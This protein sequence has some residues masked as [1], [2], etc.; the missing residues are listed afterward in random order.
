MNEGPDV[1]IELDG[2][3]KETAQDIWNPL[4]ESR[5]YPSSRVEGM[6][7]KRIGAHAHGY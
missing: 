5:H 4:G 1:I 3:N 2:E 6:S 7:R